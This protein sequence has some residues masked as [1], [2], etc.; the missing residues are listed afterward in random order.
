MI[1]DCC[2]SGGMHRHGGARVRGL[3]PPDDVRHRELKWDSQADMWV[4]RDFKRI[5][6][7][8]ASQ[9]QV[10]KAFFGTN[11]ATCRIGRASILRGQSQAQ[12]LQQKQRTGRAAF[13]PYL[14]LIIEACSEAQFSYEYRHGVT[15]YGAFTYALAKRLRKLSRISF[16]RLVDETGAELAELGYQQTPQILG[17]TKIRRARVPW[18]S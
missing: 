11:G 1:L 3:N 7:R 4:S 18:K 6:P 9:E 17:P 14:P 10:N 16:Q 15:S 13:G 12:Y 5:N 8:F 2:H